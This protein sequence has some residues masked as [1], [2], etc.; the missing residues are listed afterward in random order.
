MNAM[1]DLINYASNIAQTTIIG[2]PNNQFLSG[3]EEILRNK[4]DVNRSVIL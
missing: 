1:M 3:L 2:E 4:Y